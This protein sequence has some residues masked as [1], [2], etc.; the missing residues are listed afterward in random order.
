MSEASDS[1]P[2]SEFVCQGRGGPFRLEEKDTKPMMLWKVN[3]SHL[4]QLDFA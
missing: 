2:N 3:S 1:I 4:T